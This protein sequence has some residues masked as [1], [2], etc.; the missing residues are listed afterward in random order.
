MQ[1]TEVGKPITDEEYAELIRLD[2]HK[3]ISAIVD[4]PEII[5]YKLFIV[6]TRLI[7]EIFAYDQSKFILGI[8]GSTMDHIR[9]LVKVISKKYKASPFYKIEVN[10]AYTGNTEKE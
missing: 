1:K 9:E 2:I 3:I 5:K 10:V 8:G 6:D 7:V 4:K